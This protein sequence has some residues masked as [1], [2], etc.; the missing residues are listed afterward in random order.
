MYSQE[1]KVG[2]NIEEGKPPYAQFKTTQD[3]NLGEFIDS[4]KFVPSL[5][6]NF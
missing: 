5:Y 2:G 6:M 1:G 4:T 3:D